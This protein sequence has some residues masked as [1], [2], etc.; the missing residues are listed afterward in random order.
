MHRPEDIAELQAIVDEQWIGGL[1]VGLDRDGVSTWVTV[2]LYEAA[3]DFGICWGHNWD[4]ILSVTEGEK[5]RLIA[6]AR[7]ACARLQ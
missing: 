1:D 7:E 4:D 5:L 6:R 3:Y 2:Y